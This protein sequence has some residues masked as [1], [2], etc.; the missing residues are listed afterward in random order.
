MID[1]AFIVRVTAA[2]PGVDNF[3]SVC[4]TEH[5]P[6]VEAIG[7]YA[8]R[9][10]VT[11]DVDVTSAAIVGGDGL[12]SIAS[13]IDACV[14]VDPEPVVTRDRTSMLIDEMTRGMRNQERR[15]EK[16]AD[17]VEKLAQL[18]ASQYR[19]AGVA[20]QNEA[21][22]RFVEAVRPAPAIDWTALDARRPTETVAGEVVDAHR[23]FE[24]ATPL[25]R[26]AG[27]IREA[28]DENRTAGVNR[29]VPGN[30]A[31]RGQPATSEIMVADVDESGNRVV[32][33]GA[34]PKVGDSLKP[35]IGGQ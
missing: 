14:D 9:A 22:D 29:V 31:L 1:K 28:L 33:H 13:W 25:E 12:A 7:R 15:I 32:K 34:L 26:G 6:D 2:R 35:V 20:E 11:V 5:E 24:R 27:S 8:Q 30:M 18:V 3:S 21:Q 4:I 10:G 19:S 16:I 23:R 17:S